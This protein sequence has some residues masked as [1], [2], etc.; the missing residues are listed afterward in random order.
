MLL[1][2][3][4]IAVGLSSGSSGARHVATRRQHLAT[5][6]AYADPSSVVELHPPSFSPAPPPSAPPAKPHAPTTRVRRPRVAAIVLTD[7]AVA[8]LQVLMQR[9]PDAIGIKLGVRARGCNGLSYTMDFLTPTDKIK[10]A[11]EVVDDARGVKVAIDSKALIHLVGTTMDYK[12]TELASEFVFENP[13]SKGSCG[14]G[15]SFNV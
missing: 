6:V 10:P 5:A 13:N 15:E 9:R 1:V 12:D 4:T 8:R 11:D 3:R 2:R 14:C 7:A